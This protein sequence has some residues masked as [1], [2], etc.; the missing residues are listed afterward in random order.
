MRFGLFY[1]VSVSRP[2]TRASERTVYDNALEQVRL[3]D[4]SASI[5]A[6]FATSDTDLPRIRFAMDAEVAAVKA[7]RRIRD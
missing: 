7:T 5:A 3:A 6:T 2:C 1:E 4:P